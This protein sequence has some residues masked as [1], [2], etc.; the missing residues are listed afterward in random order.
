MPLFCMC[1]HKQSVALHVRQVA[2]CLPPQEAG[3]ACFQE[4]NKLWNTTAGKVARG[5]QP[6]EELWIPEFGDIVAGSTENAGGKKL[7]DA[8]GLMAKKNAS[9]DQKGEKGEPKKAEKGNVC[10]STVVARA[11]KSA[12][13]CKDSHLREAM[14]KFKDVRPKGREW[15]VKIIEKVYEGKMQQVRRSPRRARGDSR[16]DMCA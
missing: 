13:K 10:I 11:T 3:R 1:A 8:V 7:L 5:E 4:Y 12:F 2:C 16:R 9:G 6:P 14:R 15:L